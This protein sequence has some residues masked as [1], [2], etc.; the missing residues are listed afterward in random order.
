M[1]HTLSGFNCSRPFT[2]CAGERR[3]AWRVRRGLA[4]AAGWG[5]LVLGGAANAEA[6]TP[7]AFNKLTPANGATGRSTTP[8]VTW[9]ASTGATSYTVCADTTNDNACDTSWVSVGNV[10]SVTWPGAELAHDTTYYWQV[11]ALNAS[12]YMPADSTTWWGFTT[13]V[14]APGPFSKTTPVNA[15]TAQATNPPLTWGTSAR[16]TSYEYCVDTTNDGAC[17]GSWTSAGTSTSVALSG[18]SGATA[19]YWHVR[20]V[21][22]GGTTYADSN[23]WWSFTTQV[24]RPG[25]FGK[26]TPAN[27]ATGRL[28]SP[29]ATW[30]ASAGATS[31]EVCADT[32]N[33]SGCDTAWVSVGN[34]TSVT[35]PG[36]LAYDTTFYWQVRAVNAAGY[37]PADSTAWWSFRTQVEAPGPFNKTTPVNAATAQATSPTLTWGTSA[38]AASYEYCYDTTDDG[39][40]AGTWTSAGT[41]T[42]AALSGLSYD[43]TYFWHVR[44]TNPGGTTYGSGTATWWGFTT[45]IAKPVA[46]GKISPVD[47]A[48]GR[49]RTPTAT[50]QASTGATT[51]EVCADT[52]ND[53]GC[54][55]G[56]VSVGN[57]TSATWPGPALAYDTTYYWQVRAVNAGGYT[58]ADGG[59]WW[60]FRTQVEAPG[61]FSKGTPTN[62]ATAQATNPTLTW[63]TS[64]RAASYEYCYDT[65]DDGACAGTWMNTGTSRSVG[66]SGLSYDTMYYWQVR[67]VNAGGTTNADT[68]TWWS[69]RT[70]VEAPAAF[71]KSTPANGA[72]VPSRSLTLTWD[73]SARATSYEYCVDTTND[74]QCLG[75]WNS[76]TGTSVPLNTIF[77]NT[78]HYWQVRAVNAGGTTYANS[79]TFWSFT[80]QEAPRGFSKSGPGNGVTAQATSLTLAWNWSEL[81]ARYEYCVDTTND[82]TCAGSWT[83]VGNAASAAVNGLAYGTPYYWQVR[84][85]NPG[86]ATGANMDTWWSFTTQVSKPLP[87]GKT[88]PVDG[89]TGRSTNPAATWEAS[90]G[91]TSYEVCAD[92]LNNG[93]CDTAWVSVGNVT[94]VTWPGTALAYDTTYYWQVRA[95]NAAG[96]TPADSATWWSVRTQVEAPEA[97]SMTTPANGATGQATSLTLT[98]GTSARAASYEYCYDTT[99][100]GAC[101]GSWTSAGTNTSAGLSGL[102]SGT[103]YYWHVRATNPGGTT[104][105]NATTWWSFATQVAKPE[106]FSKLTPANGSSGRPTSP[107]ATWEASAGATGYEMCANTTATCAGGWVPVG[108]V[109]SVTWPG[110]VLDFWTTYYWQVRAVNA[111]GTTGANGATWWSFTTKA[112][113]VITWNAPAAIGY[114]TA[115]S[116]TQLNATAS[117][118]GTFVYAPASGTVMNAGAAQTLSVTFTPTDTVNYTTA[119]KTVL[120][121]VIPAGAPVITDVAPGSGAIG[122]GVTLTGTGFTGATAVTFHGVSAAYTVV[123]DTQITTTVPAAATTG[124]VR[125]TTPVWTATSATDYVVTLGTAYFRD[126]F[127]DR[128]LDR[129]LGLRFGPQND[130]FVA[131]GCTSGVRGAVKRFEGGIGKLVGHANFGDPDMAPGTPELYC[132][133]D[134]VFSARAFINVPPNLFV[135]DPYHSRI[136]RYNGETG[137]Y[138]DVPATGLAAYSMEARP[139]SLALSPFPHVVPGNLYVAR[140]YGRFAIDVHAWDSGAFLT[141][142]I[143]FGGYSY[144]FK[145]AQDVAFGPDRRLYALVSVLPCLGCASSYAVERYDADDGSL[146]SVFVPAT[147]QAA[148]LAFGP[149]GHLYVAAKDPG[150]GPCSGDTCADGTKIL[151]YNGTTGEF[152]DVFVADG[153]VQFSGGQMTWGPDNRLYLVDNLGN[154]IRWYGRYDAVSC[155]ASDPDSDGDGRCDSV[156]NCPNQPNPAQVDGDSNGIGDACDDSDGDTVVDA[157]DNCPDTPNSGQADTDSDGLGDAC[158]PDIDGDKIPNA[159]DLCPMY[160]WNDADGDLICDDVDPCLGDPI[161][162]PDGDG[163]CAAHPNGTPWDNC[164]SVTNPS[165]ADSDGDRIGD[166]CD[167]CSDDR[168]N[169]PDNDGICG[170]QDNC[171]L[172]YNPDQ[173]DYDGNSLGDPCDC[174]DGKQGP[175]EDGPDCGGVCQLSCGD[176]YSAETLDMFGACKPLVYHGLARDRINVVLVP[177]GNEYRDNMN[178]FRSSAWAVIENSFVASPR[179]LQDFDKFNFFYVERFGGHVDPGSGSADSCD[180]TFPKYWRDDCPA[181]TVGMLL[182]SHACRDYAQ[183]DKFSAPTSTY[184]K[185]TPLHEFSHAGFGL[186]DEYDFNRIADDCSSWPWY[187]LY[188]STGPYHNVWNSRDDCRSES[189]NPAGCYLFTTCKEYWSTTSGHWKSDPD[190]DIMTCMGCS[191][192]LSSWDFFGPDDLRQVDWL[193]SQYETP[194]QDPASKASV[195]ELHSSDAFRPDDLPQADQVFSQYRESPLNHAPK[196]IVVELH[197]SLNVVTVTDVRVVRGYAPKHPL[198]FDAYRIT[199]SSS[200]GTPLKDVYLADPGLL[201]ANFGGSG[202]LDEVDFDV[203]L[204]FAEN[205]RE[206]AVVD[207]P[208]GTEVLRIDV[209]NAVRTFLA[210]HPDDPQRS[211]YD[212][213]GDGV[214]DA[215]D[216]C[217]NVGNPG[218]AD[219]DADGLGDACDDHTSPTPL[220]TWATP[221]AITVGTALGG[222]Q[223]NATADVAGTFVYTPPAGTALG[224]GAGQALLVTF[225]P[226]DALHYRVATKTVLIDVVP[227]GVPVITDVTPGSGA[228]GSGVTLTGTAFTG[229]TAVTF[230]GVPAVYTVVSDTQILTTVPAGTTT[231]RVRVTTPV[232]TATSGTDFVVTNQRAT[233]VLPGC[234]AAGYEVTVSIDVGPAP[235]VLAQAIEDTP[236]AGWTVG[237]ISDGGAFNAQTSEVKWGPFFDATARVLT[238]VVTPPAGTTLAVTFAGVASFDGV[239]VPLGGTATLGR[240]EQ[241]PADA[242][243]DFRLVI[244]EV[245]GYGAAWKKGDRWTVPPAS[246]PIGHVTRAGYLWRMGETYRRD[247]GDGPLCWMPLG[248]GPLPLPDALLSLE[249]IPTPRSGPWG[250]GSFEIVRSPGA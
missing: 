12:G 61:A 196:A 221:A 77:N 182:H 155:G 171:P 48:T 202:W 121:D 241:H 148:T 193:F 8:T 183:G 228:I 214:P 57:A 67:A 56:W 134:L 229:A 168:I 184:E 210:Q 45:Q 83:D 10:T 44:A 6:A 39:A 33:D 64:A 26:L 230:Q 172:V 89:A 250:P 224:V 111:G 42:S 236:P 144:P 37:T 13:Q 24:V 194:A 99:N 198:A 54:D 127:A 7:A 29:T 129:P 234:Y 16:A 217:P 186:A 41:G 185:E 141:R 75:Q 243:S 50:W 106:D 23:T 34:V 145:S 104:Y 93:A 36:A 96:Y 195:V 159:S 240:C 178:T 226:T 158:D 245:T 4:C 150:H 84:A 27:G 154:R 35:W 117:V 192:P 28:T 138:L 85:V 227:S 22:A 233:R 63:G 88:S 147:D 71:S 130:L 107:T 212:A 126:T 199:L 14:E 79:G 156:D 59:S 73:P 97:F 246:I 181:A 49:S 203:V 142:L 53:S 139:S 162:D 216:N 180:W 47:G 205:P 72:T 223:L 5:L 116:A 165:Q 15:A 201:R 231:G 55:T 222:T 82:S 102:A 2:A 215:T 152:L 119:T 213:D 43:T 118:A 238:Y 232:W 248:A 208:T 124:P 153:E 25:D 167:P 151:R 242:N 94:S 244:G 114:G 146:L 90:A 133:S 51:Y 174:M 128:G 81:A 62:G 161:N 237:T 225:T 175:L 105:A 125:V 86:G 18:L 164:P 20:S 98:W 132:P 160:R 219:T 17:A 120:I 179:I 95:V 200:V 112:I 69:V 235:A 190:G 218:Q 211:T 191:I 9:Q 38:R 137:E 177:D 249:D 70:Q 113:P 76:T 87:F 157:R 123:S 46:F 101:A 189:A 143:D 170:R 197:R 247:V 66:L 108:N 220:I 206:I 187:A 60:G 188:D 149:D 204:P 40:C 136:V 209:R 52:T 21:N 169:D 91:A 239:V 103:T 58:P 19:Y 109:T 92:T 140:S 74:G 110:A 207:R 115:L 176:M 135:A 163:V 65:T 78:A 11:R 166:A 80:T 30:G 31:Y 131:S 122:S 32:T 1:L 3:H 100:D 173:K 68:I